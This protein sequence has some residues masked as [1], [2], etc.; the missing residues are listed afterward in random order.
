[1]WT[2]AEFSPLRKVGTPAG[3]RL[4]PL[5]LFAHCPPAGVGCPFARPS[6][7]YRLG[8]SCKDPG[9]KKLLNTAV[10]GALGLVLGT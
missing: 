5:L 7:R 1:M 6:S 4:R 3:S 2:F 10:G 9:R 8:I